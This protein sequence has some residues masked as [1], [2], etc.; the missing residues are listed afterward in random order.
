MRPDELVILLRPEGDEPLYLQ[1]SGAIADAIR[2]GALRPGMALPGT[3]SLAERLE[4]SRKT[5]DLA[6]RELEAEGWIEIR[7]ASG[8]YVAERLPEEASPAA[9]A[10]KES[11][12]FDFLSSLG[13]PP[14]PGPVAFDLR[15]GAPDPRLL[16]ADELAR[17]YHRGL[18]RHGGELLKGAG[19]KGHAGLRRALAEWLVQRRG[20]P[21]D[22]EGLL[23]TQGARAGFALLLRALVPAGGSIGLESPGPPALR[24]A[25]LQAG[26]RVVPLPVDGG[27]LV[28]EALE[29]LLAEQPLHLLHLTPHHQFPTGATLAPARRAALLELAEA[30]RLPIVEDDG[31]FEF[32][33]E[34]RPPLPLAS[35][36]RRGLVLTLGSFGR[37]LAPGLQVGFIAARPSVAERLARVQAKGPAAADPVLEGALAELINLEELQ[38]AIRRARKAYAARREAALELLRGWPGFEVHPHG[39]LGLWLRAPQGLDVEAWA[40]ACLQDGVRFHPGGHYGGD[41]QYLRLGFAAL[42]EQEFAAA[43]ALM[44]KRLPAPRR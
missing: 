35:E 39:G 21:A 8:A 40:K 1:L 31:D 10:A 29:R 16:P 20:I 6:Y 25:A 3:R 41:P 5:V 4:L 27:G 32:P 28:V 12:A 26:L 7:A 30:R 24:E 38:R 19:P 33:L 13:A 2:K 17:A 22:S 37:W 44:R 11:T 15:D 36:D 23:I 42:E 9:G 34:S 14:Q 18:R 43:A